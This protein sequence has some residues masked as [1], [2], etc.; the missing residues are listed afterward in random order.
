M[1]HVNTPMFKSFF[2]IFQ[3]RP[4]LVY[5]DS[6]ASTLKPQC[7]IDALTD[8]YT[9]YSANIARGLYATSEQATKEYENVREVVAHFIHALSPNEVIFTRN[10]TESLNLLAYT[11]TQKLKSGDEIVIT[12]MEHHANFVPWQQ[13]AKKYNLQLVIVP[14]NSEGVI[15]TETLKQ[16]I[17][18]NTKIFSFTHASNVLATINPAKSFITLARQINPDI[19]TI[20]DS[21]QSAPHIPID[22][23]DIDC[24]FLAFSSHKIFGPTGAGVL[25]GKQAQLEKLPPF[26]YGGEMVQSVTKEK[27]IFKESPYRFEAGTPAIAEVIGL[28]AALEFIQEIGFTKIQA[29]EETLSDYAL[30]QLT[31]TF[32][33]ALHILGPQ[34]RI[35]RVPLFSFTL[36]ALHPHDIAQILAKDDICIRA[37]SHCAMPLH[38]ALPLDVT[39]SARIG[40]SLYTTTKDIDIFINRLQ[41][42]LKKFHQ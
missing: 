13:L 19:I 29:H 38:R 32:G 15:D 36:D 33:N 21:A 20:I 25:W 6:V 18:P 22:V 28:G 27:T 5:L 11:L 7:V 14:F 1:L 2:P 30:K 10:T 17:T 3:N 12:E 39:A 35:K 9:H 23:V 8:Y 16:Y 4:D 37:G 34:E 31:D 40:I 41:K 26:L 24:D 42:I